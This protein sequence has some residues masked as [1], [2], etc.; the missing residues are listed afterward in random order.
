MEKPLDIPIL[1]A[2][3]KRLTTEDEARHLR[4]ITNTVFVTELLGSAAVGR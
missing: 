2:A 3:I 1:V 4:R